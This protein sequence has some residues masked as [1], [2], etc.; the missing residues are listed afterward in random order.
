MEVCTCL[1]PD[2][3]V[4]TSE[5]YCAICNHWYSPKHG[6]RARGGMATTNSQDTTATPSIYLEG[7]R[8]QIQTSRRHS[9]HQPGTRGA[10]GK[11]KPTRS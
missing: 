11:R 3:R 5:A 8:P 2:V 4:S 10:F 1:N 6:S 9:K 7:P